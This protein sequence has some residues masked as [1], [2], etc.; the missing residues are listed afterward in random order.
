MLQ[1]LDI[2]G[3]SIIIIKLIKNSEISFTYFYSKKF[4][5]Y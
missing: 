4:T 3:D 1:I 5:F 2:I